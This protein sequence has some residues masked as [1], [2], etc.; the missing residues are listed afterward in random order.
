MPCTREVPV[1]DEKHACHH[2]KPDDREDG[3]HQVPSSVPGGAAWRRPRALSVPGSMSR[4]PQ[5]APLRLKG[6]LSSSEGRRA[7]PPRRSPNGSATGVFLACFG[8]VLVDAFI[9]HRHADFARPAS[10]AGA[11]ASALR[12]VPSH[13][14]AAS[15][16]DGSTWIRPRRTA[17]AGEELVRPA[18]LEPAA[19]GSVDRRSDPTELRAHAGPRVYPKVPGSENVVGAG[20]PGARPA[21]AS[22]APQR[23]ASLRR[24]RAGGERRPRRPRARRSPRSRATRRALGRPRCPRRS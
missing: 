15:D 8:R 2:G 12:S 19:F 4:T 16:G 10:S 24:A 6:P 20:R 7:G 3:V 22:R 5:D 18:G 9:S 13:S 14:G 21:G 17:S 11:G 1:G 23:A